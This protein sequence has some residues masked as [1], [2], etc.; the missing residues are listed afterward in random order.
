MTQRNCST[1]VK[2]HLNPLKQYLEQWIISSKLE[3]EKKYS[4]NINI[5][6]YVADMY[7]VLIDY[8]NYE[9]PK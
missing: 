8:I 5:Y 7:T 6:I 9:T 1:K 3:R 2:I 4:S